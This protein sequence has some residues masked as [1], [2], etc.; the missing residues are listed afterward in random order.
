MSHV[1]KQV[2]FIFSCK[3]CLSK[4]CSDLCLIEHMKEKHKDQILLSKDLNLKIKSDFIKEGIIV[5]EAIQNPYFNFDQFKR[6]NNKILG[7]GSFGD[8]YIMKNIN[9]DKLFAVK[10]LD[11]KRI[12]EFGLNEDIIQREIKY[13]MSLVHPHIVKLFSFHE[14]KSSFFLILE[15]LE[16][17]SLFSFMQ[18]ND[19]KENK[20]NINNNIKNS[21]NNNCN[22]A[23]AFKYF[24]QV[25]SSIQFLHDNNLIHR[26]IKPENCLLDLN[27]EIKICDFGWTVNSLEG[28]RSTFCGTYE[29]MAPE[30]IKESPYDLTVDAWSLGVMLYELVHGY[31]PFRA[32]L[33]KN[34]K[35]NTIEIMQNIIKFNFKIE[36]RLSLELK[37]LIT[38]KIIIL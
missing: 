8:V 4:L 34:G 31:S 21:N 28:S 5:K 7:S 32:K 37:D 23:K 18:E 3:C 17:G 36:K 24:I 20:E 30:M 38:S 10:Q 35:E 13:H 26:D 12:I 6:I 22:E 1:C 2:N 19:K 25:A 27:K 33:N 29:Y 9:D 15:Y 11:K 14:D 16:G